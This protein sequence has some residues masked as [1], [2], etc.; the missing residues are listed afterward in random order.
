[1]IIAVPFS[2]TGPHAVAIRGLVFCPDGKSGFL[3]SRLR[4]C[5]HDPRDDFIKERGGSRD[6]VQEQFSN[7]NT[8]H[9]SIESTPLVS[10]RYFAFAR[11]DDMYIRENCVAVGFDAFV[12]PG[13]FALPVDSG[14]VRSSS[15]AIHG[16]V[17]VTHC[18][19]LNHIASEGKPGTVSGHAA[20][21]FVKK[22][23]DLI[24]GD[25]TVRNDGIFQVVPKDT[26]SAV[27][28]LQTPAVHRGK[29]HISLSPH[30]AIRDEENP[31][32][33]GFVFRAGLIVHLPKI[34]DERVVGL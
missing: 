11:V 25:W 2:C 1:M 24:R 14:Y 19:M 31:H 10:E 5:G 34:N 28:S 22:A 16:F 18:P 26:V 21:C 15:R 17:H 20:L 23:D 7:V 27:M 32:Q 9:S 30:P 12:G 6:W 13:D 4:A 33:R 8:S 29:G 3:L